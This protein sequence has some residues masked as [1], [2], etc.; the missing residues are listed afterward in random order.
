GCLP[1]LREENMTDVFEFADDLGPSKIVHIYDPKHGLKA[2]VAIDNVAR[3]PS[4]GGIRMAPDVSAEEAFRLARAM[5][6][7]NSAA[8]LPHGGGKSV[9]FGDP[10]MAPAKKELLIRAFAR[11]I[12]DLVEYIPGPD[13]GTDERCMAWFKDEIGRAVGLP[14]EIGGIP[15]DELGATGLGL[16]ASVEAAMQ[17]CDFK[18]NGARVVVQGF[19]SV[20]KHAARFLGDKGAI[21]IAACD[22]HG[23]IFNP[24]GI[25]VG[26]LI[27]LKD[28][29]KNVSDYPDGEK[30]AVDAVI[31]IE[32]EI[33]I[34]AA[35]PDVI[36]R[37]NV[38]RLKT[39]LV[40]QGANIPFT[41]EAER[42]LHKAGTLVL[43]DF[44]ANAG[45]VI[46]ASVEY[47]GGTQS[48]ALRTIEEKIYANTEE[49]LA[50]A[51]KTGSLPRQAAAELAEAR[52][53]KAMTYQK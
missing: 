12:R 31:D 43:P 9:I 28:A 18:L 23:M 13:M 35:R 10:K 36:R 34:P 42:I 15:L 49:V 30:L 7:K 5:T 2:V 39:K 26:R 24:K 53:K 11:A 52:V 41:A 51:K 4:I 33:W 21:L 6:L 50:N 25:D 40:P 16:K 3:G 27:A 46:C 47:H 20:G 37:D 8:N 19:G 1:F 29:G 14:P 45:G 22:S 44:I 48:Q 32:C 38:A 17:H